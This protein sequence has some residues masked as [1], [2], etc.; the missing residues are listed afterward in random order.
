M[1]EQ[2]EYA[3]PTT[4]VPITSPEDVRATDILELLTVMAR[5]HKLLLESTTTLAK[6]IRELKEYIKGRNHHDKD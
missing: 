1:E 2:K 5:T 4:D 6:E 3:V